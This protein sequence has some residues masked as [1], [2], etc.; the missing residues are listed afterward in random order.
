MCRAPCLRFSSAS[1]QILVQ[2]LFSSVRE[3]KVTDFIIVG[4]QK[5]TAIVWLCDRSRFYHLKGESLKGAMP[6]IVPT[7]LIY[8]NLAIC[9]LLIW[10]LTLAWLMKTDSSSSSAVY[11]RQNLGVFYMLIWMPAPKIICVNHASQA[12]DYLQNI[13]PEKLLPSASKQRLECVFIQADN[14][15]ASCHSEEKKLFLIMLKIFKL[16]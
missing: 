9:Y 2:R 3:Y 15:T 5:H 13:I 12:F 1:A 8:F 6:S 14:W 16:I 10:N 11:S 7:D 4:T